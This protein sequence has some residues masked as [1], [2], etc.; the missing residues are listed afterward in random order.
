MKND[1]FIEIILHWCDPKGWPAEDKREQYHSQGE[2]ININAKVTLLWHKDFGSHEV[3]CTFYGHEGRILVLA[4]YYLGE[5]EITKFEIV[6]FIKK[7]VF[8]F[9]IAMTETHIM[10]IL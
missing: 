2:Y 8:G 6:E 1:V 3:G 9:Q 7:Q 10:Q 4:S 5:S